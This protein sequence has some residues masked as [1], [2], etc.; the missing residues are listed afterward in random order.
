MPRRCALHG[1]SSDQVLQMPITGRPSNSSAGNPWF[2]IQLRCIEASL[3]S[4]PNQAVDRSLRSSDMPFSPL[5]PPPALR[6]EGV[7]DVFLRLV[8]QR[9]HR[10][11]GAC[12]VA[13]G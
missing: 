10:P 1:V 12:T 8:E 4:P 3:P 11:A 7:A 9:A 5:F 2:F 6:G 13:G